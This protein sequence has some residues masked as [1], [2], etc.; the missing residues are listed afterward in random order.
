MNKSLLLLLILLIFS[1]ATSEKKSTTVHFAGEIVNPTSEYVVLYKGDTALDSVPLDGNNRFLMQLDSVEEGLYNFYHYPEFQYV[2]L[3]NGDSLQIRLNTLYFDES[4]VFSGEGEEVNNF[5]VEM[6][7]AHEKEEELVYD[8]YKLEPEDFCGRIDSLGKAKTAQLE[9]IHEETPLSEK[10]YEIAKA[11]IDY[12][13][14][15]YKEPYPYYHKK[16]MGE[17]SMHDLPDDFYAYHQKV[18]FE[19]P[20]FTYLRPYYKFMKYHLGNL[21]YINCKRDCMTPD[22]KMVKNQ[23]HFNRHQLSLIDS[24]VK[25][26]VLR[27]NLFRHVA[28]EYLLKHDSEENK[29]LFIKEFHTLSGNNRHIDEIDRL[30]GDIKNLQPDK[31]IPEVVVFDVEGNSITLQELCKDGQV[32]LYFWSA[33]QKGHF[34]NITKRINDLKTQYPE[35]AF[36]GIN[37]RTDLGRWKSMMDEYGLNKSEQYWAED[38]QNVAHKLVV[39]DPFKSIIAKDGLIVDAFANVYSSF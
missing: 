38:Y 13:T 8:L 39:Y 22:N 28:F 1:C 15:I 32:V 23:L 19:N 12:N 36:I 20:D 18:N 29:E 27:D 30:Y 9:E 21:S 35:Y 5:L 10:A 4:L 31:E 2:Y 7:L 24:L 6:F 37:L 33:P 26:K 3:E 17:Q 25:Q 16:K 11:G 34:V 14:Y